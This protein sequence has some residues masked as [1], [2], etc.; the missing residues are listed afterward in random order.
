[1]E[2]R[3]AYEIAQK[4]TAKVRDADTVLTWQLYAEGG[5]T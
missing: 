5:E 4:N 2:R 3:D 1:M